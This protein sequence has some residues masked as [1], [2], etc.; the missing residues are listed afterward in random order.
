V[1]D[2]RTAGSVTPFL[3]LNELLGDLVGRVE[4]ILGDNLVGAY[5]IGSFALG[6]GDLSSDCDFLL[7]SKDLQ[8]LCTSGD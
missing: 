5:V 1:N 7:V 3:E 2:A 8:Q 6:A 4:S